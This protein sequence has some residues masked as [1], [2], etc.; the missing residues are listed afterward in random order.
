MWMFL[1][2]HL[3]GLFIIIQSLFSREILSD[4]QV[5]LVKCITSANKQK[6]FTLETSLD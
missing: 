6:T 4:L 5:K 3:K 2:F 1:I